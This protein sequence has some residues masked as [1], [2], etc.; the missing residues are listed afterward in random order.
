ME[1]IDQLTAVVPT[2]YVAWL[3]FLYVVSQGLGRIY[4]AIV[5]GGGLKSILSAIWLGTNSVVNVQTLAIAVDKINQEGTDPSAPTT[6]NPIPV[7]SK[8][9]DSV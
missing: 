1:F 4:K 5:N 9:D 7:K 3:T 6:A 8:E 2:K